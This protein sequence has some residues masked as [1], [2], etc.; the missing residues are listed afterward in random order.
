MHLQ[1]IY[2]ENAADRGSDPAITYTVPPFEGLTLTWNDLIERSEALAEDL[3][4]TGIRPGSR[5]GTVLSDHPNTMPALLAMWRLDAIPVLIDPEWGESI[6][7]G[8]LSHS[9]ADAIVA[10]DERLAAES[11]AG[12]TYDDRPE[13]PPGTAI[14]AYTSGSTAAP[15]GIPIQHDRLVAA[16]FSSAAKVSAF[17]G[18]APRRF[19]SSMRLS[20]AGVLALH[21][22]WSAAFGAEVVVLPQ[23]ID[24]A[25]ARTYWDDLARNE[26]DQ[27]VLVPPLYELLM[28]VSQPGESQQRPL[29]INASGA[30]SE[31]THS[32][33]MERF[34]A[35]VLNCYGLTE[36]TF[37][38]M[39]GD[40]DQR[41]TSSVAVGRPDLV[42]IR[43]CNEDGTVVDGPGEGEIEV[44][45]PSI[46][47]GYYDNS[48]ANANLFSGPWMRT[49]DLARRDGTGK[50]W[51][52]GRQKDAVMKGGT[53][54]YLNEVEEACVAL[55][56]VL[57]AVA[58][59]VDLPGGI[60]DLAV[61]V[62]P[63]DGFAADSGQL[64]AA[65]DHTLGASRAPRSV[66]V[67][68]R[69]LPRIGQ[70]KIDR[71]SSQALWSELT[72]K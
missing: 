70:N 23:L 37:A 1:D 12:V 59:R 44:R 58:V 62:R 26:I 61:I 10:V 34:E 48:E 57:E 9:R 33:F 15:K 51:I 2:I 53:T 25:T 60:E 46:S 29:F 49:G 54:V 64:K 67:T 52:V 8:V 47:D 28:A 41:G 13:L 71:R 68:D 16:L 20:G 6:R 36:T 3:S 40:T 63:V 56:G 38:C 14:L 35:P 65:L 32:R 4:S 42:K 45:G 66:V 22:A 19:G 5:V 17:R 50:Y 11:I 18:D 55:E 31:A 30:L 69:V 7:D 27:T 21:Y 72:G 24:I 39:I 43:L